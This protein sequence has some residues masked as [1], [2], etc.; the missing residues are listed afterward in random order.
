MKEIMIMASSE[1][2][3]KPRTGKKKEDDE[4]SLLTRTNACHT[5]SLTSPLR[6]IRDNSTHEKSLIVKR[7]TSMQARLEGKALLR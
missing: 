5:V 7:E 6:T 3:E 4:T 1:L 2:K